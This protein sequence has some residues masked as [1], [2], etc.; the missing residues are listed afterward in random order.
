MHNHTCELCAAP[1][2]PRTGK[3][4]CS[5][6]CRAKAEKRRWHARRKV[7]RP[8]RVPRQPVLGTCR[9]CGTT[10]EMYWWEGKPGYYKAGGKYLVS[11]AVTRCR[12]C[13]NEYYRVRYLTRKYGFVADVGRTSFGPPKPYQQR[14]TI[15]RCVDCGA[16]YRA[17]N[18]GRRCANCHTTARGES[19]AR[20][21][22]RVRNGDPDIHWLPLGERDGWKCHICGKKVPQVAGT[23]ERMDGATVDH[24]LPIASGGEHTWANVALAHRRCNISRGAR[25][26]AQ[27]RLVG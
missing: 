11:S 15:R 10:D 22:Q 24:L 25:G 13:Y 20:R 18:A 16:D 12:A 21:A 23:A 27:L 6:G 4:F 3:R 17:T 1:F 5:E 9:D 7:G 19:E 2:K 14:L 8:P 26:V